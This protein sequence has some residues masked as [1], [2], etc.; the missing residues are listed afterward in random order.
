MFL[1]MHKIFSGIQIRFTHTQTI[2][3]TPKLCYT[4]PTCFYMGT[5]IKLYYTCEHDCA[6]AKS[7]WSHIDSPVLKRRQAVLHNPFASKCV[8][9]DSNRVQDWSKPFLSVI[10]VRFTMRV[11]AGRTPALAALEER[12]VLA[13]VSLHDVQVFRLLLKTSVERTVYELKQ[14]LAGSA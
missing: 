12:A 10:Q 2:F 9:C 8:N 14:F 5:T 6:S 1:H 13:R 4:C 11:V 7:F 3:T